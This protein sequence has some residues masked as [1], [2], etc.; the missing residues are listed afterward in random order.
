MEKKLMV[1]I[2][3][4]DHKQ[5]E[6]DNLNNLLHKQMQENNELNFRD[7]YLDSILKVRTYVHTY[8]LDN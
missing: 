3:Q 4:S 1:Y 2:E 5:K 7:D 6:I 8:V